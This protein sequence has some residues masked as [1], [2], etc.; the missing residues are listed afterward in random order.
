MHLIVS[1]TA[2]LIDFSRYVHPPSYPHLKIPGLNAP[3]PPGAS[4]GYHPGGW[5]KPPVDE[6]GCP[7]YGDVFG[8]Q[9]ELPN[10]KAATKKDSNSEEEK[11]SEEEDSSDEEEA[12]KTSK[13][14]T[15]VEIVDAPSAK[16][17]AA[18]GV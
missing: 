16:K 18:I 8:Q 2:I 5:G 14:N 9:E 4:F 17:A 11:S 10:Y 13:K 1:Y 3:I 15:D 6:F 12:P 7:V